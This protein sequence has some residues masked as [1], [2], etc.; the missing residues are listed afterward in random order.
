MNSLKRIHRILRDVG[1]SETVNE[2]SDGLDTDLGQSGSRLSAG[3]KQRLGIARAIFHRPRFLILDEATNA[4]DEET[5]KVIFEG[6]RRRLPNV[7]TIVVSHRQSTLRF[8][9]SVFVMTAG[10]LHPVVDLDQYFYLA[11]E[12]DSETSD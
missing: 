1:L 10:K 2:M 11:N 6:L 3:Q 8:C 12:N 4:N 7:A 9:N 5:E